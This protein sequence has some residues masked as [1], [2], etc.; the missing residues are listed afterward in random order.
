MYKTRT[1]T[2]K[3]STS[4]SHQEAH[5]HKVVKESKLMNAFFT[6]SHIKD[7]STLQHGFLFSQLREEK[8]ILQVFSSSLKDL[9]LHLNFIAHGNRMMLTMM[10]INITKHFFIATKAAKKCLHG[11]TK[12]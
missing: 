8:K 1:H 11:F 5:Q 10:I 4:E 12:N 2:H 7:N 3:K 9:L 6:S